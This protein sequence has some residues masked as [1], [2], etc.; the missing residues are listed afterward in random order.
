MTSPR[1]DEHPGLGPGLGR[2]K[3]KVA[4]VWGLP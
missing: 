1:G 4:V 3:G 2:L